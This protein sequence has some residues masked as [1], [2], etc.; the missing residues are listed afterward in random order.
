MREGVDNKF[1]LVYSQAEF[2]V[3]DRVEILRYSL[4]AFCHFADFHGYVRITCTSFV[5][6]YQTLS[7]D[8]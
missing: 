3:P 5:F 4:G 1:C 7:A 8:H 2:F 6:P